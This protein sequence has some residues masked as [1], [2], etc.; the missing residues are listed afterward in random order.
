[1]SKFENAL[2][3]ASCNQNFLKHKFYLLRYQRSNPNT[4]SSLFSV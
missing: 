4:G 1:M 3:I 2:I